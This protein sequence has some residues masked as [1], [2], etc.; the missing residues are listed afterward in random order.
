MVVHVVQGGIYG[1]Y[2]VAGYEPGLGAY[3]SVGNQIVAESHEGGHSDIDD[4]GEE[5][6]DYHVS[7]IL[8][9]FCRVSVDRI[10]SKSYFLI[11]DFYER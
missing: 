9:E 11:Y 6:Y 2:E 8:N 4:G 3:G 10:C 7:C 5:A 1:E